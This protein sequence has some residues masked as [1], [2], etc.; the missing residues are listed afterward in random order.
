[1]NQIKSIHSVSAI[2]FF[3]LAFTYVIA[4]LAFRNDIM[5]N[6]AIT[7]MRMLDTPFALI[8]LLYG[9]STL[10]LELNGEGENTHPWSILIVAGCIVL[11]GLVVFMNFAF[12]S[13]I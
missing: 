7:L 2:Y 8:A 10:Y 3:I 12:P 11:F 1:M 5:A 4:A 9:G 13:V 6:S